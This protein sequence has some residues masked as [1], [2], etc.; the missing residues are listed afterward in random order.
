MNLTFF[1]EA[2]VRLIFIPWPRAESDEF[3]VA[4]EQWNDALTKDGRARKTFTIVTW[5]GTPNSVIER[6]AD[7]VMY[8][9]GHGM[10]DSPLVSAKGKAQALAPVK[11]EVQV[12][13]YSE[14]VEA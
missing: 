13:A 4:S 1:V 2:L 12:A 14:S 11:A 6:M 8:M 3:V 10:P 5:E 7:G 9:R